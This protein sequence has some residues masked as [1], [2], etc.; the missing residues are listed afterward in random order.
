[1]TPKTP[2]EIITEFEERF[3][4]YF[5]DDVEFPVVLGTLI[6]SFLLSS[7]AAYRNAVLDEAM[8]KLPEPTECELAQYKDRCVEYDADYC[9]VCSY[10]K[11]AIYC[12][13]ALKSE[14]KGE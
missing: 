13:A 6:K 12:V 8:E 3:Y 2:E 1:M 10:R 14:D 9:N 4:S 5:R 7:L 11:R